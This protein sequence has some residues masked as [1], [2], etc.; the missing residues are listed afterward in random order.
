MYQSLSDKDFLNLI[1]TSEDRLGIDYV[2]EAKTRRSFV[3]PFLCDVVSKESNYGFRD[4]R[5]WGVIHATY[6]LGIL[7]D[8]STVDA[9]ILASKFSHTYEIDWIWDA[10]PECYC[11]LGKDIIPRLRSHIEGLKSSDYDSFVDEI[12]GLWNFWEDYPEE[13][14]GIEEFLLEVLK[15]PETDRVTRSNL[16]ADFAQLGRTD[17]KP[18]FEDFFERGEVD[19]DTLG[20]KDLDNFFDGRIEP[21][22][23]RY[24]LENFYSAEEIE[25]RQKRWEEEDEQEEGSV[26]DFILENFSRIPRNDPCPCGSGKKFK[27]CHLPWAEQE[28]IRQKEGKALEKEQERMGVAIFAE[29][30]AETELRRFLTRKGQT[31]LFSE[32]KAKVLEVIK[33]P[34][35]ELAVKGPLAYFEPTLS[36][37]SFNDK[38]EGEEFMTLLTEY[39][40]AL[41]TQHPGAHKN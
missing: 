6:I 17:L 26:E 11:R 18:L 9:L 24:N 28:R 31:G 20:R 38:K 41:A 14:Q 15:D 36:K 13:R 40:D 33:A 27:K 2:E 29:R 1:F 7:G 34:S 19:L 22:T 8:P 12:L 35:R 5:F 10:V 3:V 23:L 16:I 37:I 39:F 30:R 4:K 32:L 25:T 21:A